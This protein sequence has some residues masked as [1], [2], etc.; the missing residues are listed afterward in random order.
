MYGSFL[1]QNDSAGIRN[2][3]IEFTDA[4]DSAIHK[5]YNMILQTAG[6]TKTVSG[7]ST[8]SGTY[9]L[10]K[11][12]YEEF[13]N[14][15]T[16]RYEIYAVDKAGNRTE[17]P[18]FVEDF[19]SSTPTHQSLCGEIQNFCIYVDIIPDNYDNMIAGIPFFQLGEGG[20]ARIWTYGH[21]ERVRLNFGRMNSEAEKEIEKGLLDESYKLNRTL[22][23]NSESC[24]DF[25]CTSEE[26]GVGTKFL[27]PVYYPLKEVRE[28]DDGTIEYEREI[29]SLSVTAIK[30]NCSA[31]A[32]AKYV[33]FDTISNDLHYHLWPIN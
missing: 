29:H 25:L 5:Q 18:I 14:S 19:S 16:L 31:S 2:V 26:Y 12:L 30:N 21:V 27:I 20:Y 11:N 7:T 6:E 15:A 13:P 24:A 33:V 28:L 1:N 10:K 17:T 22:D 32:S 8:L 3:I 4:D 23:V 9:Q